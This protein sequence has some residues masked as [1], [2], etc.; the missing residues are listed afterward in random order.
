MKTLKI[1]T[2]ACRYCRYYQPEGRRGGMCQVLEV[3]VQGQ[4]K[5][6]ALALPAFTPAWKEL[7][8]IMTSSDEAPTLAASC[9]RVAAQNV[10]HLS[11]PVKTS[12]STYEPQQ[13]EP[14]LV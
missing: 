13:P 14:L 9:P 6:C 3:P 2:S 5:A 8:E 1:V 4:W 7:E 12:N 10:S 11:S